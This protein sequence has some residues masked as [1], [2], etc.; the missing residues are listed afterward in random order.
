MYQKVTREK[1]RLGIRGVVRVLLA[2]CC[3]L[4]F[5]P[6]SYARNVGAVSF[7]KMQEANPVV[8][9]GKVV[10][11]NNS[12]LPGVSVVIKGGQYGVST[13]VTGHFKLLVADSRQVVL[14]FSFVG[15]E[16]QEVVVTDFS[17]EL[18]VVMKEQAETLEEVV[19]TGYYTTTKRRASGSVAVLTQEELKNR[20]PNSVD[21][22]LQGLVA[23]VAVTNVGR[24]GAEASIRI[25]GTNT[26]D[27]S[28]EPLWVI[29]GV[30]L[31][32]EIPEFDSK[33]VN[34]GNLNEIFM[35][36]VAGI[37]PLDIANITIL[38]DAA[39]TAIYGSRAAG[40]VIVI[41]TKQGQ[42]GKVRV[43]YYGRCGFGL[44]PQ[45]DEEL[46]NAS[47][48][49]AWEEELWNEFSE[50]NFASGEGNV[51]VIGIVGMLKADRLGKNGLLW[52]QD[53]F[54]KM[55][56]EE[57]S[58][59]LAGLSENSTDWYKEIF[60]NSFE[61]SHNLSFSGGNSNATYY[62]SVGY[63]TEEGLLK[64]DKFDKYNMSLKVNWTPS[65]KIKW[66]MGMN[67]SQLVSDGPAMSV[68][69]FSYAYFAN[70]YEKVYNED[71]SYRADM[72]F[73]NLGVINES[74]KRQMKYPGNGFNIIR[75]MKETSGKAKKFSATGQAHMEWNITGK[76]QLSGML[77]Y[78]YIDHKEENY[79]GKDTYAA[80]K[81]RLN[82]DNETENAYASIG[83][84]S[85]ISEN[86]KTRAQ[87]SYI[88]LF[89]EKH[90]L[91]VLAGTELRGAKSK[92][93]YFKEY[94]YDP[95]T[96]LSAM[97]ENPVPNDFDDGDYT[98]LINRLSGFT[99][100]ESK[101]ASFYASLEY[102]FMDR[103]ILNASFRTDG[104]NNFGS[105]EQFNPTWSLGTVWNVD[106][107]SFMEGIR[108][109]L[110]RLTLR[111]ATGFTG[112]VV[113][114]KMKNLVIDYNKYRKWNELPMG[115]VN[116]APNPHLR[117]EKTRD[118]K[119]A[120]DFGL[121]NDRVSGIVETY[122]RK[123]MNVISAVKMVSTTGFNTLSYNSSEI[124]NKGIEATIRTK[125]I[126]GHDFRLGLNANLAWNRNY[127]SKYFSQT[128]AI[129]DGKYVRYPINSIF[130]GKEL[131]IDPYDGLYTYELR[132]D[133]VVNTANDLRTLVNYRYYLGTSIAPFTGGFYL[134]M[135]YKNISLSVGGAYSFG[136]K[137]DN[138]V[139]DYPASYDDIAY[140]SAVKETPQTG[141]SDLYTNH[142]N[143]RRDRTNRWTEKN[144]TGVK[145]PRIVDA[146]GEKLYLDQY[147]VTN[148]KITK[149]SF[150]ESVSYL[151]I[152]DITLSYDMPDK[153]LKTLGMSSF[154]LSLMMNNFW[155]FT[156]FSGI[157]PETPGR[158]YPITRSV[159][160]GI[161]LGF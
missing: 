74:S 97:P 77:S 44:R 89:A 30:P 67:A 80:W 9:K 128:G 4:L 73:T 152:R 103:Y 11:V 114:G 72:T 64:E 22:L 95:E 150:L 13:D 62:G 61:M 142:L 34:T 54:E 120:L 98:D 134:N 123:S 131:R 138:R 56:A 159:A 8:M 102:S 111:V 137:I 39:A 88:D 82:F 12:P 25:R 40:G 58:A 92:R 5:S 112:N 107:E 57:K 60:R 122:F 65:Q 93:S 108:P 153:W 53:D 113:P 91:N 126:D 41:T 51:P 132:P 81:D 127:L 161:N 96:G 99:R 105:K 146:Y 70:P 130:A 17:K 59:Y 86:Y 55:S 69:P 119:V 16:T 32:D 125:I 83:R 78:T 28:N 1:R 49:I 21:N 50:K 10:D 36:G 151:R 118:F 160:V 148:R 7:P 106:E 90:F 135:A 156:N 47:E 109:V 75:E 68:D 104:S 84:A 46:M 121:F 158:T 140:S 14:V 117:W 94:G 20:I 33:Q 37:N 71:G 145:Y 115:E 124:K 79:F 35:H 38:K 110:N 149:G 129:K 157:D 141:Y 45:R 2:C 136:G 23:G 27:G 143:V 85:G 26:I 6:E 19:K 139:T 87:L 63:V 155:T 24:P 29:D 76:L 144:T 101:Y 18:F 42:A 43:N 154:Q 66:G 100:S 3:V 52:T 15:M 31:Q 147:N 48:K 133:A 116:I